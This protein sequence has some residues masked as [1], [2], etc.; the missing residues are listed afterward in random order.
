M[1]NSEHPFSLAAL[2]QHQIARG[3][4]IAREIEPQHPWPKP[5]RGAPTSIRLEPGTLHFL[6]SQAVALNMSLQSVICVILDGVAQATEAWARQS[7][8]AGIG[9][10]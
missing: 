9:V 4:R 1:N 5:C 7:P 2:V 3:A 10:R 8:S 6:Q